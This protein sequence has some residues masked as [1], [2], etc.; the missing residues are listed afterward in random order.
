MSQPPQRG[1]PLSNKTVAVL[2]CAALDHGPS[3]IARR[4]KIPLNSV[5]QILKRHRDK[6]EDYKVKK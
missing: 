3:Y 6:I 2:T 5:K 4:L 1:R